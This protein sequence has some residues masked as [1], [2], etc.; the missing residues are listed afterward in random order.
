MKKLL[1]V[2][3]GLFTCVTALSQTEGR[4]T[5]NSR[6]ERH[7]LSMAQKAIADVRTATIVMDD[8]FTGRSAAVVDEKK[9]GDLENPKLTIDGDKALV[10]GRVVFKNE[11]HATDQGT[12]VAIHFTKQN[13]QWRFSELCIGTCPE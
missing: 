11:F 9:T 7:L 1:I 13:G 3:L 4:S 6:I 12:P 2:T 10:T 5:T 8:R